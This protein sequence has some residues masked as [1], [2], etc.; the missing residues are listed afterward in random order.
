MKFLY[1]LCLL[2]LISASPAG[3][4]VK[5]G[6]LVSGEVVEVRV[7]RG[8]EVEKGDLLLRLDET[9]FKARVS[10]TQA[11]LKAA[12]AA[13]RLAGRELERARELYERTLLADYELQ[14]AQVDRLE[15]EAEVFAARTRLLE[16]RTDLRRTQ[17]HA[18]FAGRIGRILAYPGQ[19]VQNSLQVQPLIEMTATTGAAV[20]KGDTP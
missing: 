8:Q 14:K 17:L 11:Q 19:A 3:E 5:L 16:A 12:E 20:G 9:L 13:L 15:A 10:E 1:M 7:T 4:S 2:F 18:P 6:V